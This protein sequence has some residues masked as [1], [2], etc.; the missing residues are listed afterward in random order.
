MLDEQMK[1]IVTNM[2]LAQKL[3][4]GREHELNVQKLAPG[5]GHDLAIAIKKLF[6]MSRGLHGMKHLRVWRNSKHSILIHVKAYTVEPVKTAAYQ[7]YISKLIGKRLANSRPYE[8]EC[9]ECGNPFTDHNPRL[10]QFRCC[11]VEC[12]N[13]H[14]GRF[15]REACRL[16]E[17]EG[18]EA[19]EIAK[20]MQRPL[21]T[22]YQMLYHGRKKGL[23]HRKSAKNEKAAIKALRRPQGNT[24]ANGKNRSGISAI[25]KLLKQGEWVSL[26]Q[27][28]K[29]INK[30]RA[31]AA[32]LVQEIAKSAADYPNKGF[33]KMRRGQNDELH[34]KMIPGPKKKVKK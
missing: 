13:K 15:Q 9:S 1:S 19:P 26:D 18:L 34:Y 12:R 21:T 7:T 11:S 32:M 30:S 3:F 28:A 14:M 20:R 27:L 24:T 22:V 8:G 17:E 31:R 33:K 16:F 5:T 6:G 23:I 25:Y 2:E 4:D 10:N 29:A